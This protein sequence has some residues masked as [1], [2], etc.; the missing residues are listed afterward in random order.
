M[1]SAEI[2]FS[3]IEWL[4]YEYKWRDVM[5]DASGPD[6]DCRCFLFGAES[7]SVDLVATLIPAG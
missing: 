5:A 7:E 3:W 6:Y 4:R 2:S 1:S